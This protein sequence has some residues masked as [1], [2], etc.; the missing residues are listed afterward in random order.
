MGRGTLSLT[1]QV[2]VTAGPLPLSN[3]TMRYLDWL[4]MTPEQLET[5]AHIFA[6]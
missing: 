2:S 6:S 5:Y 1:L 4:I 3:I